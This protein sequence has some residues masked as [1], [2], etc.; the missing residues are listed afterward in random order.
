VKSLRLYIHVY[1]WI[2]G[3]AVCG[4]SSQK[5]KLFENLHMQLKNESQFNVLQYVHNDGECSSPFYC[6]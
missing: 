1:E 5:L 4:N 2:N 3:G 6:I